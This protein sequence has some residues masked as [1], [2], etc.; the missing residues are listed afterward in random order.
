MNF[1]RKGPGYLFF[2]TE[3]T[4]NLEKALKDFLNG[5]ALR[6]TDALERAEEDM[7]IAFVSE[8]KEDFDGVDVTESI[9]MLPTTPLVTMEELINLGIAE[10]INKVE[11]GAGQLVMRIPEDGQE[12]IKQLKEN[13]NA[14]LVNIIEG[15]KQ[16]KTGDTILSFTEE[17]IKTRVS[18]L[19]MVKT[20]LLIEKPVNVIHKELRRDVVR[21]IT[22]GLE[23]TQW[24]E[25]KINIYDS[26]NM[27][28]EQYKR[29]VT[30]LADLELGFILGESWTKDH[31]VA[32]LSVIAYQIRLFTILPPKKIKKI[33]IGLEYDQDGERIVDYDLYYNSKKVQWFEVVSQG[34][35]TNRP[36]MAAR[37]RE[38]LLSELSQEAVEKIQTIED[39]IKA[40]KN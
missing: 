4:D 32:L 26:G 35:R 1:I 16:G 2:R 7:T 27:Y 3:K 12:I 20:N 39:K 25:L 34:V 22:H 29:L 11:L 8:A 10:L 18:S 6:L 13:Y 40:K 14:R 21:H 5:Q 30:A 9:I 17:P 23:E 38:S 31:A 36:N 33:L 19:Q 28:E 15:I 24:Y 37:C